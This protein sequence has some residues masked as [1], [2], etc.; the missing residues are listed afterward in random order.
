MFI[1]NAA[2]SRGFYLEAKL[3]VSPTIPSICF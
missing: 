1:Y 2:K 3:E